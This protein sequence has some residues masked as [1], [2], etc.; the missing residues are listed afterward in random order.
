MAPNFSRAGRRASLPTLFA[1]AF[2]L[3]FSLP[4]L[5][6]SAGREFSTVVIDAGHGGFD[7]GGIPGQ[8]VGKTMALDVAQRLEKDRQA[9]YQ[10]S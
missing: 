4:A 10:W 2:A 1:L 7:R 8:G 5:A 6:W 9:G 3:L